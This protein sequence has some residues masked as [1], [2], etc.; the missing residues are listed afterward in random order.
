[1]RPLGEFAQALLQAAARG[2]G[3]V[4]SLAHRAQVS[5][6]AAR[7]TASRLVSRGSL[8]I[9]QPGRPALLGLPDDRPAPAAP[10]L[11]SVLRSFADL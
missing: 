1:M 9:V 10:E 11:A 8:S 3:D 5:V 2:P 6:P 4:V 7:Y